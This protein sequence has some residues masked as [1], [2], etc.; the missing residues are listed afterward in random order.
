MEMGKS[1][2]KNYVNYPQETRPT[3][4]VSGNGLIAAGVLIEA[5]QRGIHVPND[6]SLISSGEMCNHELI[7]PQITYVE[8]LSAQIG[9]EAAEMM[10]ER[11]CNPDLP[12]RNRVLDAELIEGDSVREIH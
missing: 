10:L 6:V 3:A 1:A 4:I 9:K 12:M 8:S 2:L 5:K 7:E 11:M